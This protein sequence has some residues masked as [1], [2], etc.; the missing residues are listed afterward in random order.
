MKWP[1]ILA[2]LF[3]LALAADY[4]GSLAIESRAFH[5]SRTG[6]FTIE[7][8]YV[9][10]LLAS[11][12]WGD[13]YLETALYP[14]WNLADSRFDL[15]I[16]KLELG[17]GYGNYAFGFGAGPEPLATLRLLPPFSLT[18]ERDD[19]VPG[20][21]GGWVELYPTSSARLRLA[22]RYRQESL[23]GVLR[24]DG[25]VLNSD[26]QATFVYD[27]KKGSA[28]LGAGF[29]TSM[30]ETIVYG[31][32]WCL[33]VQ[34]KSWRGGL[35]ASFYFYGGLASAEVAYNGGWQLAAAYNLP[36]GE[37]W[38]VDSL[39]LYEG[40]A[41]RHTG[42]LSLTYLGDAGDVTLGLALSHDGLSGL[43]WIPSLSARV[44]Y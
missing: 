30:G 26:L 6:A 1:A 33:F 16:S 31:E 20:L 18:D 34:P 43:T 37:Y 10:S 13:A 5:S 22:L 15:G 9:G 35:G 8:A 38:T 24:A 41:N 7:A 12:Y 39:L 3:G 28:A 11:E 40:E 42:S 32:T 4:S 27:R 23:F 2:S 44:Y 21:W 29:S 14:S 17:Y 19:Y 25:R 36:A